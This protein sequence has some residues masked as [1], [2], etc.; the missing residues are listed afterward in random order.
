[1]AKVAVGH[2]GSRRRRWGR[3][4]ALVVS[5]LAA[6]FALYPHLAPVGGRSANHGENGLWLRYHWYFGGE[7]T[8]RYAAWRGD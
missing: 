2:Q 5:L 7:A 3:A 6:D 4:L 1:M 8:P